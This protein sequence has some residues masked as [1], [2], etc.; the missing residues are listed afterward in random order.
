MWVTLTVI[1]VIILG[2]GIFLQA[3]NER[4]SKE[5]SI[6]EVCV[7]IGSMIGLFSSVLALI[8]LTDIINGRDIQQQI[9]MYQEENQVI[10]QQI[11]TLV[12]N[13]IEYEGET[14][15]RVFRDK[16]WFWKCRW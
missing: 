12:E 9:S 6:G 2:V 5:A 13:Y 10:E 15:K 16:W 7:Y 11:N 4:Y 3:K 8:F 14:F 1:A